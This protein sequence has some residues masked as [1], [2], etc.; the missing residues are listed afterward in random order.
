LII[1]TF[2]GGKKIVKEEN[3]AEIIK[4]AVQYARFLKT[5]LT[6]ALPIAIALKAPRKNT[7]SPNKVVKK[8]VRK[9]GSVDV[10]RNLHSCARH[11]ETKVTVKRRKTQHLFH[12]EKRNYR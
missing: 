4:A 3:A 6:R 1:G 9:T 8:L 10:S 5:G 12:T 2:V 7:L 11:R